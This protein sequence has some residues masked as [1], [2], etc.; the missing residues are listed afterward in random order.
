MTLRSSSAAV[1][2]FLVPDNSSQMI[3]I[4]SSLLF[5]AEGTTHTVLPVITE[6]F[7]SHIAQK[8]QSCPAGPDLNVELAFT[9]FAD[10]FEL[11]S[12]A[13][14]HCVVSGEQGPL[15]SHCL[16]NTVIECSSV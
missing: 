7:C 10:V 14:S 12:K 9:R 3:L 8:D 1:H 13:R 15:C 4:S 16:A 5:K 6:P 2:V 11:N